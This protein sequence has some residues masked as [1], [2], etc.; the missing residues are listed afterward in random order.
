MKVFR[1]GIYYV[2]YKELINFDCSSGITNITTLTDEELNNKI[3]KL[4]LN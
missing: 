2:S 3:K 1:N 4:M